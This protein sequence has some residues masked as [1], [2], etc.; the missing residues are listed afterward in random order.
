MKVVKGQISMLTQKL[1]I[2]VS[3][4]K[5][6]FSEITQENKDHHKILITVLNM[7]F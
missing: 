3:V 7:W 6:D 5:S 1:N 4:L 2:T